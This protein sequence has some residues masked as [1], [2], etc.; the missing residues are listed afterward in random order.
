MYCVKCGVELEKGRESC[1][2]CGTKV[3]YEEGEL[4][5]GY[6][7]E[8]PEVR[9]NIYKLN[10]KK[11]KKNVYF[12]MFMI[13]LISI[14]EISVGNVIM[15]GKLTWGYFTILSIILLDMIIFIL[16]NGWHLKKNLCLIFSGLSVF[17]LLIDFYDQ[18]IT[19]SLYIG[20]PIVLSFFV[21]GLV[22]SEI[23]KRKTSKITMFN[24]FLILVGL[25]IIS[26]EVI[27]SKRISWSLLASIPLII[28]GIM[29]KHFYKE[30]KNE[31]K[32][33]MHL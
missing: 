25:F 31:L 7:S 6:D 20:I 24:Y 11:L 12:I 33:R 21:L 32:K 18:K 17:L 14:L 8:Y 26:I 9:V 10:K 27:V 23:K 2:L 3:L 15:D 4:N 5:K 19:W 1:P 28:F 30:Y 13:S 29:F 22:F 16:T